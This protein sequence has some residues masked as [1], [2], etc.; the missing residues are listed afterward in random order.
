M[1]G[2][3]GERTG[4]TQVEGESADGREQEERYALIEKERGIHSLVFSRLLSLLT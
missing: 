1:T 4:G 2:E 3:Y